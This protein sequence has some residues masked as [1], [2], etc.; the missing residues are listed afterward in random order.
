M[1]MASGVA[2]SFADRM[3]FSGVELTVGAGERLALVGEN[4]SG[5]STLLRVLAGLD[6]PDAGVVTRSGRVALLAQAQ[7]MGGSVLEAVTPPALAAAQ[8]AF[9]AASAA[10]SDGSEAALLAFAGA[11]EAYRLSGGYDF[12]GR[13]AAVLAGLGLDA[14]AR[15]DR[16]SGG[17][18]RRVL[19]AA[20]LLAPADVYL[21]DE[22]TNHLDAGGAAWLRDWIRASD[23]AFVL[24]SHDRAFL[25]EVATGVAEL[26]RGT[27]TAVS[28]SI[29]GP[30]ARPSIPLPTA[31]VC[32]YSLCSFQGC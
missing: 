29:E 8:V 27:L 18:A 9:E 32:G 21:L 24:A 28:S 4:G 14:G 20:L 26:E 10:L 15:A 3:V 6:A 22:P 13:A 30:T 19:L 1:L 11:E 7:V 16:L 5:K 2:R 25:D 17:Q 31:V 12:A 23:A